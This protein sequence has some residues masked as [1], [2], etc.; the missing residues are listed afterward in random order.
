MKTRTQK[1][2]KLGLATRGQENEYGIQLYSK[3]GAKQEWMQGT[4]AV[5]HQN[6]TN[7][8]NWGN[9]PGRT[10][11]GLLRADTRLSERISLREDSSSFGFIQNLKD[12]TIYTAPARTIALLKGMLDK[13]VAEIREA[14]PNL[15]ELIAV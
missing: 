2:G 4:V 6:H 10:T 12:S 13:G 3:V 14:H 1:S 11:V 8:S 5:H 15:L 9:A 7:H